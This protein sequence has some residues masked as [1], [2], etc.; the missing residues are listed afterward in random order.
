MIAV[1]EKSY[2]TTTMTLG[3]QDLS[4]SIKLKSSAEVTDEF[5]NATS[6]ILSAA[7]SSKNKKAAVKV[8]PRWDTKQ[9]EVGQWFS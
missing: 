3:V 8:E 6:F 1:M 5:V 2:N 9:F 4:E 7:V